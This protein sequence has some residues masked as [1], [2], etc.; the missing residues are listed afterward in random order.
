MGETTYVR[1]IPATRRN[2][3]KAPTP[4]FRNQRVAFDF[5]SWAACYW[6]AGSFLKQLGVFF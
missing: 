2:E 1:E 3:Q 5:D 6:T 4:A